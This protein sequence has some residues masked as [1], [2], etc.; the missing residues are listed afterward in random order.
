M[1]W[2]RAAET[3]SP[4]TADAR[5]AAAGAC[6]VEHQVA[7]GLR[8]DEHG[9]VRPAH[10]GERVVERDQGRVDAGADALGAGL[11]IGEPL[12]D[13]EQLDDVAGLLRR[14]DLRRG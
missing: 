8:L 13:G 2:R 4:S 14:V 6:A 1:T 7:R 10:R 11:L 12:A 5:L 3:R 9:V